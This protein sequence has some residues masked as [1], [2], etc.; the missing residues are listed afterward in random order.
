LVWTADAEYILA[1]SSG[2]TPDPDT[3]GFVF[4]GGSTAVD[5]SYLGSGCVGHAMPEPAFEVH[6][7]G[8]GGRLRFF[9]E[10]DG[11]AD[12]TMVVRT[13]GG[14]WWCAD[15]SW[16]TVHPTIEFGSAADGTYRVWIGAFASGGA[17]SGTFSVTE[18]SGVHP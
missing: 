10:A 9:F 18:L 4:Y 16:G 14:Q 3:T 12:T 8:S 15:D 7:N 5:V 2:F 11:G 6:W 13:P 1:L 17:G